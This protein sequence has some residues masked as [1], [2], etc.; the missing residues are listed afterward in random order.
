MRMK[1][2]KDVFKKLDIESDN[3]REEFV[4]LYKLTLYNPKR[5]RQ[6]KFVGDIKND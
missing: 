1:E 4:K 5:K 6:F 3:K 2:I